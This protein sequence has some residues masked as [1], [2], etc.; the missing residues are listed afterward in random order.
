M[1][2]A[3]EEERNYFRTI[4]KFGCDFIKDI[5]STTKDCGP[6]FTGM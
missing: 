5:Y 6:K 2:I 4:L 3:S 1:F